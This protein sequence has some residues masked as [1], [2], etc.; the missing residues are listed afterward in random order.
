MSKTVV[1]AKAFDFIADDSS[2]TSFA[3]Y[4]PQPASNPLCHFG[5]VPDKVTFSIK[6]FG[7]KRKLVKCDIVAC[8]WGFIESCN[9]LPYAY[10]FVVQPRNVEKMKK[11][12]FWESYRNG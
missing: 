10:R 11:L 2:A 9:G 3:Y 1:K 7:G 5:N 4:P 12:L 8:D 6:N